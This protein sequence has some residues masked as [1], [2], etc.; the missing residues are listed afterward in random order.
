MK[1]MVNKNGLACSS[2]PQLSVQTDSDP[3]TM[4]ALPHSD[5]T[6]ATLATAQGHGEHAALPLLRDEDAG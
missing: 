2:P 1:S 5:S 4:A 6:P 3:V